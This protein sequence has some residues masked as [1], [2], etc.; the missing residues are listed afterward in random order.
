MG[1]CLTL[2]WLLIHGPES[3]TLWQQPIV[4]RFMFHC[5]I[6]SESGWVIASGQPRSSLAM[7]RVTAVTLLGLSPPKSSVGLRTPL[8]F[9]RCKSLPPAAAHRPKTSSCPFDST[10]PHGHHTEGSLFMGLRE[11]L[12]ET[13]EQVGHGPLQATNSS[14]NGDKTRTLVTKRRHHKIDLVALAL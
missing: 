1:C 14:L 11:T 8:S 13:V 10:E 6:T 12:Q 4:L 2:R 5:L 7:L 9:S 3:T